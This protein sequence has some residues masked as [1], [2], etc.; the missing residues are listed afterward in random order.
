MNPDNG[1]A[2]IQTSAI[3]P[4]R[5]VFKANIAHFESHFEQHNNDFLLVSG[6]SIA[7]T[8]CGWSLFVFHNWGLMDLATGDSTLPWA[9]LQ[10]LRAPPGFA[11]AEKYGEAEPGR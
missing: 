10:R 6:F 7:D 5:A 8:M 3:E 1:L 11:E 9:Y 2:E 4:M